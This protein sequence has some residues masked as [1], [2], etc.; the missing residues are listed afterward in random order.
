MVGGRRISEELRLEA[1]WQVAA[2]GS[3]VKEVSRRLGAHALSLHQ[4][5]GHPT[6]SVRWRAET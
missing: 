4:R 3:D 2:H 6:L 1:V 5:I